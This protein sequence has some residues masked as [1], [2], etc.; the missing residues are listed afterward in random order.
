MPLRLL[1]ATAPSPPS[2]PAPQDDQL[3]PS[4]G[5]WLRDMLAVFD[6][7]PRLGILGMNTYRLCTLSEVTN[8]WGVAPWEPDPKTGVRWTFAQVGA[9]G[10]GWAMQ[11][12]RGDRGTGVTMRS[13]DLQNA[14]FQG[15]T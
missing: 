7:W 5:L 15:S 10:A 3:P 8:R 12:V 4:N 11:G 2:P 6:A 14:R 13:V 9:G 1:A